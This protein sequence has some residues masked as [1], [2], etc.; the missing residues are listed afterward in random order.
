MTEE[1]ARSKFWQI[2][3][4]VEYCHN[5]K[6]VHRDLKVRTFCYILLITITMYRILCINSIIK[7]NLTSLMVAEDGST[8]KSAKEIT[9]VIRM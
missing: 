4:A 7:L 6:I 2:L 8:Q 9:A 5:R 1:Q 3:S